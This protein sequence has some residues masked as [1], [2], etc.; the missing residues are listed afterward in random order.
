[1]GIDF[2]S[3][4]NVPRS[5]L[6]G[7]AGVFLQIIG[8]V[9]STPAGLSALLLCQALLFQGSDRLPEFPST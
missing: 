1:M 7:P 3:S 8:D 5:S 4:I 6:A 9:S 2:I